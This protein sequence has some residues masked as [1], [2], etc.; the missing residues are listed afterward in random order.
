MQ[1]YKLDD[2]SPRKLEPWRN[3]AFRLSLVASGSL[4]SGA[5]FMRGVL[6]K[7][8]DSSFLWMALMFVGIALIAMGF[9]PKERG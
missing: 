3:G 6:G 7:K 1:V 4:F 8:I 5:G 2:R 9:K